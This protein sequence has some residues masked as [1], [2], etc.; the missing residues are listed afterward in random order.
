MLLIT[1]REQDPSLR[2]YSSRCVCVCVCI[3]EPDLRVSLD[4]LSLIL[5]VTDIKAAYRTAVTLS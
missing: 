4:L 2:I 5:W 3:L 1:W